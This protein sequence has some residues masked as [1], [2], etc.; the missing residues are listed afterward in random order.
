M[1]H[2]CDGTKERIAGCIDLS[3]LRVSVVAA[4]G[5]SCELPEVPFKALGHETH[6]QAGL[7][8]SNSMSHF[9][10]IGR[11][12]MAKHFCRKL[13][14]P[15]RLDDP[16]PTI[17]GTE[18][19]YWRCRMCNRAE[20]ESR[21]MEGI[22]WCTTCAAEEMRIMKMDRLNEDKKLKLFDIVCAKALLTA[23]SKPGPARTAADLEYG[24]E[25]VIQALEG[26]ERLVAHGHKGLVP[27]R[28]RLSDDEIKGACD[29]VS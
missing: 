14:Y 7:E 27:T 12:F 8:A 28:A 13:D 15:I 9:I 21:R 10:L 3:P 2:L 16:T 11:Q 6:G 24:R 18:N 4:S 5:R 17:T 23:W 26:A 22:Y 1:V 29:Y 19:P 25:Y 20:S